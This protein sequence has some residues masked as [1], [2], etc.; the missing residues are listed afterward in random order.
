M[1]FFAVERKIVIIAGP[2]GKGKGSGV[3]KGL[4]P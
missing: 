1:K 3:E 4:R 2:S